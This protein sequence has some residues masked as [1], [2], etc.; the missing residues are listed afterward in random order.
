M[1]NKPKLIGS[2]HENVEQIPE[3]KPK[4]QL[5]REALLKELVRRKQEMRMDAKLE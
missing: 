2:S 5:M 1:E 3:E 4:K